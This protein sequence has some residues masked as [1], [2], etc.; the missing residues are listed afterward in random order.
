MSEIKTDD[1]QAL[2]AVMRE[3]GDDVVRAA[4]ECFGPEYAI[5]ALNDGYYEG[6][7]DSEC[8]FAE[9]L[10]DNT[11]MMHGWDETARRYFDYDSYARD[12]FLGGDYMLCDG[13][14]FR[15]V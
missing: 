9:D 15:R 11:G 13:F 8:A 5:D 10:I 12:L 3:Y 2:D 4:I 6:Q 14:V 1:E 7:F